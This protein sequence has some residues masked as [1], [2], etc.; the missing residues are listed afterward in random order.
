M[1]LPLFPL[2]MGAGRALIKREIDLYFYEE[3]YKQCIKRSGSADS[4]LSPK[5]RGSSVLSYKCSIINIWLLLSSP[6]RWT[7]CS[8][9]TDVNPY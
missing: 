5:R 3:L 2:R 6:D 9:C 1:V 8:T 4:T 7:L